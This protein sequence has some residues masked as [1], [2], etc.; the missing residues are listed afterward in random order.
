MRKFLGRG[1]CQKCGAKE[2]IAHSGNRRRCS[3]CDERM[4]HEISDLQKSNYMVHGSV[5]GEKKFQKY[6]K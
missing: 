2:V 4:W 5:H 1:Q 3:R 6:A